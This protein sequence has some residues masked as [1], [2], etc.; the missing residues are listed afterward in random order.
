MKY[1][2][3][4]Q[5]NQRILFRK[6]RI[7]D[8]SDW[9]EFH[10]NPNTSLHSISELES[11]EIECKKWY[12]KQFHRYENNFGGMNALIE[13]K[14]GILIGHCGLLTQSV[15]KI[16]ELEIGYSL[17]P[18]FWNKGFATESAIKCRDFA[19]ENNLSDSVISII[20]LTNKPSESVA[21]KNGMK[22]EKVTE[23]NRNKVN[24]Y[25]IHKSEWNRT[26]VQQRV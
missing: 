15:D 25:R 16:S 12:E 1:L 21:L 18:K 17:L 20:S 24:I 14:T 22:I 26:Y 8:F 13:K 9:L 11:P 10:K 5:E 6:I 3:E 2:L 23:Y 19:F 7:S 4:N